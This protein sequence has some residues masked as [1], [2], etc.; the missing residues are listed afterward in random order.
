MHC[1]PS[2]GLSTGL[3]MPRCRTCGSAKVSAVLLIGPQGIPAFAKRSTQ[4]SL[5]VSTDDFVQMRDQRLPILGA[6]DDVPKS[7]FSHGFDFPHRLAIYAEAMFDLGLAPV[8]S[9]CS[10]RSSTFG[11]Q[12]HVDDDK[13]GT[14]AHPDVRG[15][16]ARRHR[17]CASARVL[18]LESGIFICILNQNILLGRKIDLPR[19]RL[20]SSRKSC[21]AYLAVRPPALRQTW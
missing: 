20:A 21:L 12:L 6:R 14:R 3:V 11:F 16:T 1:A 18:G 7:G 13:G 4:W 9:T 5:G 8:A 15:S 19:L 2:R 17:N 10:P